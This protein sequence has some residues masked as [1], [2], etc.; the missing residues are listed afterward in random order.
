MLEW[1][2]RRRTMQPLDLRSHGPKA[3][4]VPLCWANAA[5]CM[6]ALSQWRSAMMLL[7]QSM[8]VLK[9]R[10]NGKVEPFDVPGIGSWI[11]S[12][13]MA[14]EAHAPQAAEALQRALQQC[15]DRSLIGPEILEMAELLQR[16][17]AESGT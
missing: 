7:E 9:E 14:M 17:S 13:V 1:L 10:C 15:P 6:I 4:H 12:D 5:Y 3:N 8:R 16:A 11:R 2:R